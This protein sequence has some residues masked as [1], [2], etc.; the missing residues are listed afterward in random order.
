MV[1]EEAVG[2]VGA[3]YAGG[4]RV[5]VTESSDTSLMINIYPAGVEREGEWVELEMVMRV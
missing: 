4:G 3:A 1:V 2:A 5:A